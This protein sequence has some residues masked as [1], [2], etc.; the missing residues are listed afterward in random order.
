MEELALEVMQL[1][2]QLRGQAAIQATS[3]PVM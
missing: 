3:A 1:K 2:S